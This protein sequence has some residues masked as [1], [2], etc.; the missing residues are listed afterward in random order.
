MFMILFE[1]LAWDMFAG[2]RIIFRDLVQGKR[3]PDCGEVSAISPQPEM[4]VY[5]LSGHAIWMVSDSQS[6]LA[7]D[8]E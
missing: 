5:H 7:G 4:L 8:R 2:F 6:D 1:V 3:T